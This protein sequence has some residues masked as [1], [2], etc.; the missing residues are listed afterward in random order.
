MKCIDDACRIPCGF[1][2]KTSKNVLNSVGIPFWDVTKQLSWI[3]WCGWHFS[4]SKLGPRNSEAT[5]TINQ[6]SFPVAYFFFLFFCFFTLLSALNIIV[7]CSSFFTRLH[8]ITQMLFELR[9]ALFTPG[10]AI[11][12][13]IF[14]IQLSFPSVIVLR[15]IRIMG[16]IFQV[17]DVFI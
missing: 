17:L 9:A 5:F 14:A 7:P 12:D 8:F 15:Y 11:S 4:C 10:M 16:R 1:F 13:S 2:L 3:Y 6:M